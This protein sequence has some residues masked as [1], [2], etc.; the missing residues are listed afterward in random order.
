M[1]IHYTVLY[2]IH[3]YSVQC[4]QF[5]LGIE[6]NEKGKRVKGR[7]NMIKGVERVSRIQERDREEERER[8]RER[9][10]GRGRV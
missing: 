9:E 10:R 7:K 2:T 8:E 5:Y 1:S 4:A 6:K 3:L